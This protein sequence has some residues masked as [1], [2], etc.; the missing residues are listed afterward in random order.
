MSMLLL[1]PL[2]L[3]IQEYIEGPRKKDHHTVSFV[4][5]QASERCFRNGEYYHYFPS[6]I[7]CTLECGGGCWPCIKGTCD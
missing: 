1:P 4:H 3:L 2:L 6:R 5:I 7:P